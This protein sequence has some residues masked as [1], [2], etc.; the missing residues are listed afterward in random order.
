MGNVTHQVADRDGD[1]KYCLVEISVPVFTT[2]SSEHNLY[3]R[4]YEDDGGPDD[5][6]GAT[7]SFAVTSSRSW[8]EEVYL[9]SDLSNLLADE[10]NAFAEFRLELRELGTNTLWDT[11]RYTQ[12]ASLGPFQFE[13]LNDDRTGSTAPQPPSFQSV[14]F[15]PS[16]TLQPGEN[17]RVQA[18][19]TDQGAAGT[20]GTTGVVGFIDLD[21]NNI[22]TLGL[23]ANLYPSDGDNYFELVSGS[24][25]DGIW[26]YSE[27]VPTGIEPGNYSVVMHAIDDELDI[28][29]PIVRTITILPP[30]PVLPVMNWVTSSVPTAMPGDSIT[31]TGSATDTDGYIDAMSFFA[32]LDSNGIWTPGVDRDLGADL[33]FGAGESTG[34]LSLVMPAD[35]PL[36]SIRFAA[37]AR[38]NTGAWSTQNAWINITITNPVRVT[39]LTTPSGSSSEGSVVRLSAAATGGSGIR[40]VSFFYDRDLNGQWTPGIDTDVGSDFVGTDGWTIDVFVSGSIAE[41][42]T[43]RFAANAVDSSGIWGVTP[44]LRTVTVNSGPTIVSAVPSR[45]VF[46]VG[47]TATV[48]ATGSDRET[49]IRAIT[50]FRDA[51]S[52]GKWD[53]GVDTDLGAD[54]NGAD[55][56]SRSFVVPSGWPA[57]TANI[58]VGAVDTDG[59]WTTRTR[60][61][62]FRVNSLPRVTLLTPSSGTVVAG[63]NVTLSALAIDLDGS[64]NAVTFFVD[65]N[66]NGRW[67]GGVDVDLGADFDGANGFTR[68]VAVQYTW[69]AG[70]VVRFVASARDNDNAWSTEVATAA[71][72][73][74]AVGP[75]VQ[76]VEIS[77][78]PALISAGQQITLVA[79][80]SAGSSSIQAVTFFFDRNANNLWDGG[81]DTD[82]GADFSS[83][84]GWTRSFFVQGSWAVNSNGRFVANAVDVGGLW[85]TS[86]QTA[87]VII[88]D[89]PTVTPQSAPSSAALGTTQTFRVNASDSYGGVSAVTL[90]VDLNNDGRW[91]SGSDFDLGSATR[92]SGT[93]FSGTWTLTRILNWGRGT[94]SILGDARDSNSAWAG[95]RVI[96]TLVVT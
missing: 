45:N 60:T 23:E 5:L 11:L 33:S 20:T 26:E 25:L 59:I 69:N 75:A 39:S 9:F 93:S 58:V 80:V 36:G 86:R 74:S 47:E 21:G 87:S 71:V 12:D 24:G 70:G 73:V 13:S 83:G 29:A 82:L 54:F 32:D 35:F 27:V 85:G 90:F 68:T 89:A 19:V 94:F 72:N 1:G 10:G 30:P 6:W 65:R 44:A 38:D 49:S 17:M 78:S 66:N 92:T 62:S 76:S 96:F 79:T 22:F 81:I 50:L 31:L 57:G 55:G 56:W 42:S 28:S 84:G 16:Q 67:D 43:A 18:R 15:F 91:T 51:N 77:G 14:T 95:A 2:Q 63:S 64:V 8:T 46:S 41:F 34:T 53:G 37:S 4:V 61:A 52:N 7:E 3:L 48:T 40:A 88:N